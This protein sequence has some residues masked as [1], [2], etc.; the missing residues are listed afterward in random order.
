M[1]ATSVTRLLLIALL[2]LL[3]GCARQYNSPVFEPENVG[4]KGILQYPMSRLVFI[5]GMCHH[6]RSWFEETIEHALESYGLEQQEGGIRELTEDESLVKLY[7]VSL[8]GHGREIDA[9]GIVFSPA[10]AEVK[11][12]QL[13]FDMSK[14]RGEVCRD[15]DMRPPKQRRKRGF[16]NAWA[17]DVF[18]NDCLADA[19]I[20][21][22]ETGKT[23]RDGFAHAFRLIAEYYTTP[24]KSGLSQSPLFFIS[25]SL[26]SKV[27]ADSLVC[28]RNAYHNQ[29]IHR[30]LASTTQLFMYANQVP[31]LNTGH[32]PQDCDSKGTLYNALDRAKKTESNSTL[33]HF[34]EFIGDRRDALGVPQA[35]PKERLRVI[36]FTDP[37]DLLSYELRQQDLPDMFQHLNVIQSNAVTWFCVLE[38][39]YRA[40]TTYDVN[41]EIVKLVACG[42][43][44]EMDEGTMECPNRRK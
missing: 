28:D 13:C 42:H 15:E 40:H 4:F 39:P 27:L 21:L 22:G 2:L 12:K 20:Y 18:L 3:V 38:N 25:E 23:V 7:H 36:A 14:D 19:V 29:D 26:G 30:L 43:L 11:R 32:V 9:F 10:T 16:A 44:S 35:E 24:S 17:K 37:N 31:I 6:N 5:H 8:K 41:E 33:Y 1:S 34:L